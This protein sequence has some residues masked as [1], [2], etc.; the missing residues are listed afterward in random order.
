MKSILRIFLRITLRNKTFSLLNILGLAIG[1]AGFILIMLWVADELSYD[2]YNE[3]AA[4]IYKIRMLYSL[5][6]DENSTAVIPAPTAAVLK[7]QFPE[8][9]N[10]VR[11]RDYGHSIV[12]YSD[13]CFTEDK[14]IFADSTVFDVFTIPMLNGKP[15][16]ALR[17]PRTITMSESMA[18][19]YFG[20]EDPVGKMLNLDNTS[21][22]LVTGV[23]KD[24]P[25]ASH[26]HFDFIAS[27]YS[28][29]ECLQD[30]WISFNFITYVL[31]KK[32]ANVDAFEQKLS[33]LVDKYIAVQ[34][35]QFMGTTWEKIRQTGAYINLRTQ[36]LQDIHLHSADLG[37]LEANGDI[38]YVYIFIIVAIFILVLAC[39]NFTNL[40]TAK[41]S[42]RTREVGM[43][44][45]FGDRQ[46]KLAS[47]FI[48]ESLIIVAIACL[49]AIILVELSMPYFN[50]LSGKVLSFNILDPKMGIGLLLLIIVTGL[51]AG[52]YPAFYLS[53]FKP[54]TAIRKE[55]FSGRKKTLFRSI[56]VTGQFLIS[57]ILLMSTLLLMKQMTF[58]QQKKLGY[59]KENLVVLKNTY[60]LGNSV[61]SFKTEVMQNPGIL[62][63]TVSSYL[64]IPSSRTTDAL[65][66]DGIKTE[67]LQTFQTWRIDVDYIRTLG[68]KVLKGRGFEKSF[69]TDTMTVVINES[70]A[71]SMGWDDPIG[72]KI[73][74]PLDGDNI[75]I[76]QVIGVVEDFNFESVHVPVAPLVFFLENSPDNITLRL[77]S[78]SDLSSILKSLEKTWKRFAQ[79]QPFEYTFIDES[80]NRLYAS[81]ARLGKIL[82]IFT[83]LAFFVS[84]LGLFGL[85]LFTT[86]QRKKEIGIRKVNGSGV[87]RIIGLL[88]FDFTKL[89]VIAFILACPVSYYFMHRWLENFAYRT[90]ISWWIFAVTGLLSYVITMITIGFQSYRAATVN[91]VETLKTE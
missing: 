27:I 78:N 13:K 77:K 39:I 86:E 52:S 67:N 6:G 45:M 20:T 29:N 32:H 23:Y 44:K 9:E 7:Q 47:Q 2:K 49:V 3:K 8:V 56:L 40:S 74:R 66:K 76:Y 38:Q 19:K 59:D 70:T 63:A 22:Y 46:G 18:K 90:S 10:V 88:S 35:S 80:L 57:L 33:Y 31:L 89:V 72:K 53:S 28:N 83:G 30:T 73:G 5:Q 43:K 69:S 84:C 87:G 81:E 55:M 54:I 37:D 60:L 71:R 34:L 42:V 12:R 21:D 65:F 25:S 15:G 26:F 24:I 64:P 91:P 48:L 41:A 11:F 16:T 1:M 51:L 4:R 85:A 17:A 58:I 82:G 36:K 14:I 79:H 68:L 61:E 75:A 50:E 62:S